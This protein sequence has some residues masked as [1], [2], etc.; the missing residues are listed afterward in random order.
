MVALTALV[1]CSHSNFLRPAHAA[2]YAS[3][4]VRR[5]RQTNFDFPELASLK[6]FDVAKDVFAFQPNF[7]CSD[8][9]L[10]VEEWARRA[11][12]AASDFYEMINL[13][14]PQDVPEETKSML[15]TVIL[16]VGQKFY[17]AVL[18][19]PHNIA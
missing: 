15:E 17:C 19:D 3:L 9:G 10:S 2:A 7:T 6:P 13:L 1:L 18:L 11:N 12:A 4:G 5:R 14:P 8:S 16:D